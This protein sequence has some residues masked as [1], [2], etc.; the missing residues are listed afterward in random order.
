MVTPNPVK[1]V[2]RAARPQPEQPAA[3]G[4]SPEPS[5]RHRARALAERVKEWVGEFEQARPVRLEELRRQLGWPELGGDGRAVQAVDE[6]AE[7]EK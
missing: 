3:E 6:P 2:K 5:A 4:A 1:V 7:G